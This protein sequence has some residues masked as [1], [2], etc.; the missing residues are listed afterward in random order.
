MK[1]YV[2]FSTSLLPIIQNDTLHCRPVIDIIEQIYLV[3]FNS[4]SRVTATVGVWGR[5]P[6]KLSVFFHL[7]KVT[8]ASLKRVEAAAISGRF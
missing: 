7:Q 6:Q 5:S 8:V 3:K 4:G 2:F 1:L